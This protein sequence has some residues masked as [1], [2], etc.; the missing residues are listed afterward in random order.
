MLRDF[1]LQDI[2]RALDAFLRTSERYRYKELLK[3][4]DAYGQDL[5]DAAARDIVFRQ[6]RDVI[7]SAIDMLRTGN[8]DGR[9]SVIQKLEKLL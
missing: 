5:V 7:E 3:L 2:E 9:D 4:M 1:E 6:N 8:L